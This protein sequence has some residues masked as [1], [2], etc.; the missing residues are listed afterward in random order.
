MNGVGTDF[1]AGAASD[2]VFRSIFLA[3]C[4]I[5]KGELPDKE[6]SSSVAERQNKHAHAMQCPASLSKEQSAL[7]IIV[8]P[9][10]RHTLRMSFK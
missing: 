7:H 4:R 3:S 1:K 10:L 9:L 5:Y 2:A 6:A 8:G